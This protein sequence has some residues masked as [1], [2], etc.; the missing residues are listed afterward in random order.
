M[1]VTADR[2][3]AELAGRRVRGDYV[4]HVSGEEEV[5]DLWVGGRASQFRRTVVR[6]WE[7]TGAASAG[8]AAGRIRSPMPG[9][10]V[11][12]RARGGIFCLRRGWAVVLRPSDDGAGVARRW[13]S[14]RAVPAVRSGV[15]P[16]Q[17]LSPARIASYLHGQSTATFAP[18]NPVSRYSSAWATGWRRAS[19]WW[20]WRP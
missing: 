4:M 12:V 8:A 20:R 18:F 11:K 13:G 3:S 15:K 1:E 6:R 9:K 16:P 14:Q 19:P 5:L 10:V 7:R 17:T 2:V